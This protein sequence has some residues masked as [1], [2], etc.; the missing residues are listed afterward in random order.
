MKSPALALAAALALTAASAG[1][2]EQASA[3]RYPPSSVRA[4]LI[5]GGVAVTA[6]AYGAGFAAASAWPEV[7]G[8]SELKIPIAGPWMALAKNGCAADDPDCGAKLY[9]RGALTVVGGL[10]QLA[11]LALVGEGIF[12]TTEARP[13]QPPSASALTVRAAP[14]IT[15]TG[16]GL[17]VVGT[18]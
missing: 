16:M 9:V 4:K 3:P 15:A 11:G 2:E 8:S 6:L 10:A 5:V 12:M 18:F 1:A 7:P 13:A 14:V 17:G